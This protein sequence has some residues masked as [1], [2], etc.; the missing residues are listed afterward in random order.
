MRQRDQITLRDLVALNARYLHPRVQLEDL[1]RLRTRAHGRVE[2]VA[3]GN[4]PG[5]YGLLQR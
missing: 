3:V 1:R 5:V 4:E 2:H